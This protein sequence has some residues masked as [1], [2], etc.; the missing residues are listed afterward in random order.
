MNDAYLSKYNVCKTEENT[1]ASIQVTYFDEKREIEQSLKRA[2]ADEMGAPCASKN[3]E[4]KGQINKVRIYSNG[5][6][7]TG[8]AF[9]YVD[10]LII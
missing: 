8:M 4:Q 6:S 7:I 10:G 3:F 9:G 1:L 5:K 2:G